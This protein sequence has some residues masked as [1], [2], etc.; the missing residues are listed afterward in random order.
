MV[1]CNLGKNGTQEFLGAATFQKWDCSGDDTCHCCNATIPVRSH[2]VSLPK[3]GSRHDCKFEI[4][5]QVDPALQRAVGAAITNLSGDMS[6]ITV[7]VCIACAGAHVE[8]PGDFG[9]GDCRTAEGTKGINVFLNPPRASLRPSG[10]RFRDTA[11]TTFARATRW[12]S[13][14]A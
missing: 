12:A 5:K 6:G 8:C 11:S 14:G 9:R 3:S 7:P 1:V 2:M 10:A 4:V 13:K